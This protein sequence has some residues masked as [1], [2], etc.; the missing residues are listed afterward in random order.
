MEVFSTIKSPMFSE[1][2]II[3]TRNAIYL[4][5]EDMLFKTLRKMNKVRPFKLVFLLEAS[6]FHQEQV[7]Q[8]LVEALD[9][10]SAHGSL[11]FLDS[12][13]TIRIAQPHNG[14]FPNVD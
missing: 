3:I 8:E 14:M 13:P 7:R 6:D 4:I 12:P 2:A 10:I 5:G 9:R 1:L 11:D